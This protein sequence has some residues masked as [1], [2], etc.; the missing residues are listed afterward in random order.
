YFFKR[1]ETVPPERILKLLDSD[2]YVKGINRDLMRTI[3]PANVDAF[4]AE[5]HKY[6]EDKGLLQQLDQ[7][8]PVTTAAAVVFPTTN[9]KPVETPVAD[10]G[11]H[12]KKKDK[13]LTPAP[14]ATIEPTT[15]IKI[16]A[17]TTVPG[18]PSAQTL[19]VLKSYAEHPMTE[20]NIS[21]L[22][23]NP[24][25]KALYQW[26]AWF[27]WL[28]FLMV[29][30]WLAMPLTLKLFSSM[31]SGA[32]SLSKVLGF[33][34]FAW[35]VWFFTSLKL[36]RFTFGSCWLW[37]LLLAVLSAFG[38]WKNQ[39]SIKTLY[40]KWGKA[41]LIQEG[42]FALAFLLFTIVRMYNPH[43]HDP[44][45]EGY[46]GGGEA[47]MDYGFLAS[48]VRGETFPPQ[49]MWMAGQPI[50]YTFYYGHLMMGVLTKTLGLVPAIT[51]NLSLITLFAM[52]FSG[53]F[54][55]AYAIS[56][57]LASGW[58]AGT[59]CA[60]TGNPAGAKQYMEA[61]HQCFV[62]RSFSPLLDGTYDFWG[63]TRVIP[64]GN[65][66]G[67]TINEFPYF[68]VLFGD[69]HAHTLAMPFAMLLIG[70]IAALYLSSSPKLL[71]WKGDRLTLLMAGLLLGGM[72]FLNTWEVPVW[73]LF[74]GLV[75]L[76]RSLAPL[77]SMVLFRG[78]SMAFAAL[79]A[80]LT[81][82]GWLLR[83][84]LGNLIAS[85]LRIDLNP[86]ALGGTTGYLVLFGLLGFA[87]AVFWL[88]R[89]KSTR[90]LALRFL[91]TAA[92]L[93]VALLV[94]GILWSPFFA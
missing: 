8:A 53:A 6:L 48:V 50:G 46:N 78:L 25:E 75:L 91:S 49:N 41:W 4:I 11:R 37:F 21:Q 17:P 26:R 34:I 39:K 73:F 1:F 79:L 85:R 93:G 20:D 14:V 66:S 76:V 72:A 35:V 22:P 77:N 70:V 28:L 59:I 80:A 92:F 44:V 51:Y 83:S 89:Q 94:A 56:G 24:K 87:A 33:F 19:Q 69:M 86:N 81:L 82:L 74:L 23:E 84:G 13:A 27:S 71:D 10:S 29:L 15:E 18:L 57:R 2:D 5:R 58:I 43:I 38:F 68:S 12:K 47:G 3:T 42:A 63:P 67:S 65:G 61:I 88:Y 55:V 54:G 52:I 31:P 7:A 90:G 9:S 30:G 16:Q 32:Y 45:G 60:V 40:S 64:F 36:C 62:S